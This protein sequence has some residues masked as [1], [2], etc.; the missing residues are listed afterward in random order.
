[1]DGRNSAGAEGPSVQQQAALSAVKSVSQ[2][3]VVDSEE[4]EEALREDGEAV[5]EDDGPSDSEERLT[6]QAVQK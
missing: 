3:P 4:D 1:M 6:A 5:R 2:L